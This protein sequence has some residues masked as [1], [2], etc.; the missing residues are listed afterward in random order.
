MK[1]S[2]NEITAIERETAII[3]NY[4]FPTKN[5]SITNI[6]VNGRHPVDKTKQHIEHTLTLICYIISGKG[7]FVI[8]GKIYQVT[9]GDA[10]F[11]QPDQ[12]YYIEGNVEYLVCCEPAYYREQHE[13]VAI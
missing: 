1:V 4:P 9:K 8:E 5:L 7:T 2:Q 12:K 6:K 13:Q 3:K 10:L 11:I